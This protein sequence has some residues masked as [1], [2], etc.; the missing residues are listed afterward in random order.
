[1][2]AQIKIVIDAPAETVF[3]VL[4]DPALSKEWLKGAVE[5]IPAYGPLDRPGARFK[6]RFRQGNRWTEYEGHLTEYIPGQVFAAEIQ[7]G[8]FVSRGKYEVAP[9]GSQT[10]LQFSIEF[11]GRTLRGRLLCVPLGLFAKVMCRVQVG[12]LK[13]FVETKKRQGKL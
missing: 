4:T 6:Q 9:L 8:P 13:R 2:G 7:N 11:V 10:S 1:M 12:E 5:T 3:H